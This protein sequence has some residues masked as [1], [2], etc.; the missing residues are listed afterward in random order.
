MPPLR[1]GDHVKGS[2]GALL[3]IP[4][5]DIQRHLGGVSVHILV[6]GIDIKA[7]G[8]MGDLGLDPGR[9]ADLQGFYDACQLIGFSGVPTRTPVRFQ[10]VKYMPPWRPAWRISSMISA[11]SA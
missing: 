11:G 3:Q 6:G 7:G 8:D 1:A 4:V 5:E 10:W 9:H 2:L